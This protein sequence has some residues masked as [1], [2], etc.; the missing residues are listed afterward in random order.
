MFTVQK[1]T[2]MSILKSTRIFKLGY[3]ALTF[4]CWFVCPQ[5]NA[6]VAIKGDLIYTMAGE[7]IENGVILIK[8][9]KIEKVGRADKITIPAKYKQYSSKVVT[10]GLIDAHTTVGLTGI[11]NQKHDQDQLE[12]SSA[13]QPELRASDAY[14]PLEELVGYLLSKGVT[15]MHTGHAPGAVISGQ[16]LIV[17]TSGRTLDE[18]Q[19]EG[20]TM[21]T[22]TLGSSIKHNYKTPGTRA[23]GVAILRTELVKAQEY[24]KKLEDKK[25]KEPVKRDL[26]LEPLV[27][28]LKGEMKALITAHQSNDIMT[29]IR[30]SKEFGFKLVIDGGAEAYLLIKEIKEAGAEVILH[31]TMIRTWGE[32]KNASMETASI[33]KKEGIEVAIQSGYESYVPK[34]RVILYEAGIAAANGLGKENALRTI[35][36]NPAKILNI[37]DRVG[38]IEKDKDADIVMFDGDPLEYL[39]H[40]CYVFIDGKEVHAGCDQ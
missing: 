14:N 40:V 16:T 17:K 13:I 33:L 12:K 23:K 7:P 11:Y 35:T 25:N 18:V 10:P 34:T 38:T 4:C 9:G 32:R 22:I 15:T 27:S 39:T 20:T 31:P 19:I 5:L 2:P 3:L 1:L 26:K 28:L 8:D 37:D 24:M 36:I 29:A 6:Q 30:L 21:L